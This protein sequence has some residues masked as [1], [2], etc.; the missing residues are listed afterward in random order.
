MLY[1]LMSSSLSSDYRCIARE[2]IWN[3]QKIKILAFS[4]T[5]GII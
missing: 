1:M 4:D 2:G 5:T 3:K